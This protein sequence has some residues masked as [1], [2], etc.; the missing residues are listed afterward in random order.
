MFEPF[1]VNGPRRLLLGR[2]FERDGDPA[3]RQCSYGPRCLTL[4][5]GVKSLRGIPV[6]TYAA[7]RLLSLL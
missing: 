6:K 3:W 7:A 5:Y 2:G 4:G 1:G